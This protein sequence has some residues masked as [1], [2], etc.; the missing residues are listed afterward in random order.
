VSCLRRAD[1]LL[2]L[3]VVLAFTGVVVALFT[4][5]E[6]AMSLPLILALLPVISMLFLGASRR[7]R[8]RIA[9]L[10]VASITIV[11]SSPFLSLAIVGLEDKVKSGVISSIFINN[12]TTGD[13]RS[14]LLIYSLLVF[15]SFISSLLL[16]RIF[17][18][19]FL[20]S[21]S[22]DGIVNPISMLTRL[23]SIKS[24]SIF[25]FLVGFIPLLIFPGTLP[26]FLTLIYMLVAPIPVQSALLTFEVLRYFGLD[27]LIGFPGVLVALTVYSII[28]SRQ[29]VKTEKGAASFLLLFA[30]SILLILLTF[31]IL[32]GT[33]FPLY[34]FLYILSLFS[35]TLVFLHSEAR[36]FLLSP[37]LAMLVI[38]L[39]SGISVGEN[40]RILSPLTPLLI[41][42][43]P[44]T[45]ATLYE[46][47]AIRAIPEE[48]DCS[49]LRVVLI[50][51]VVPLVSYLY[52]TGG[53]YGFTFT[54]TSS[55][56]EL[57]WMSVFAAFIAVLFTVI[58]QRVAKHLLS[59]GSALF[60]PLSLTILHPV[61]LALGYIFLYARTMESL[62]FI[63]P[64]SILILTVKVLIFFKQVSLK[65]FNFMV[66]LGSGSALLLLLLL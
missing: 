41:A 15:A 24:W 36:G 46:F 44:A 25:G 35:L 39:F 65:E 59:R 2:S 9:V 5:K 11:F 54:Q 20:P 38:S 29:G 7:G 8:D 4:S 26:E 57:S 32:F 64:A 58:Q 47:I 45:L 6:R 18:S 19:Y 31:F 52:Y 12:L 33:K 40:K 30:S 23:S 51:F 28:V 56:Q 21:L 22:V 27:S 14:T 13:G 16:S 10:L 61:G 34:A 17:I 62:I 37:F 55:L 60:I 43:A 49:Y 66:L 1:Y 63:I 53:S 42:A 3:G 50:T 48:E